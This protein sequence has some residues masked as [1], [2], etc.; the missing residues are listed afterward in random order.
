MIRVE[1]ISKTFT[2][3]K[4]AKKQLKQGQV[5]I[6]QSGNTFQALRDVSFQCEK[7]EV[8]GLLGAN[9]AGKTTT[10]R[11]LASALSADSGHIFI[12]NEDVTHQPILAKR[13]IGFLSSKTGL[14]NRLTAKENIEYFGKLHGMNKAA[15]K[16]SGE[17][18]Y[19]Q[20]GIEEYL[21]RR[22]E[23]LSSGMTQKVS[24]ARAVI[25]Q[26]KVIIFDEPTT[27]L[28]IMATEVILDF[29]QSQKENGVPVIFSTHHLDEVQALADRVAIIERGVTC[30]DDTLTAFRELAES[31]DLRTAFKRGISL[32]EEHV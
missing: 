23:T 28:D 12:D 6:R 14:Y 1:N 27:G 22:V 18:L 8:L 25:H 3:T 31:G 9:G 20:L 11:I 5:D 7:G 21:N 15:L 13:H 2:L 32:A 4:E 30:F 16:E 24:I 29:I 17:K 19:A 10:L 26:P